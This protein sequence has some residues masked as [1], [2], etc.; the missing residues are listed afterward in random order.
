MKVV[1]SLLIVCVSVG[2]FS[3]CGTMQT[4]SQQ[5]TAVGAGTGGLIGAVIGHNLG[6]GAGDR[7]K[8][9]LIGAAAGALLGY[10]VGQS[11]EAQAAARQRIERLERQA[12]TQTVWIANSNGSR[13]AVVLQQGSGGQWI[14]PKGEYYDKMPTEEQLRSVYG[15]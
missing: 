13:T 12:N 3:G 2:L 6:D 5:S 7:D 15:F 14:G 10:Q 9:A 11:K 1:T 4:P 8:G